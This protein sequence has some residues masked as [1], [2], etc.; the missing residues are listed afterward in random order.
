MESRKERNK[1]LVRELNHE[2][3]VEISKSIFKVVFIIIMIIMLIFLYMYYVGTSFITINEKTVQT[4]ND[5][6][7]DGFNLMSTKYFS[8]E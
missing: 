3:R 6:S 2:Q 1:K 8:I 4:N 7:F 5:S